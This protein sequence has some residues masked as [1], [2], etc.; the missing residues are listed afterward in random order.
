MMRAWLNGRRNLF[1]PAYD[2]PAESGSAVY[3]LV[4]ELGADAQFIA[5]IHAQ[6]ESS[7]RGGREIVFQYLGDQGAAVTRKFSVLDVME[8]NDRVTSAF[9]RI[10]GSEIPGAGIRLISA[11]VTLQVED[12]DRKFAEQKADLSRQARFHADDAE[13]TLARL[14]AIRDMFLRD[15][16]MAG[17]W[18]SEGKPERLLELAAH[19]NE[20]S[21]IVSLL[22]GTDT[23]GA[24]ADKTGALI[25]VF[26]TN[27]SPDH[28][29]HLLD[30]LARVFTS[31]ERPD[32]AGMLRPT[33]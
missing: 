20:F 11:S 26:L 32:L 7:G 16:A 3:R 9:S 28:R 13:T 27:L 8:A 17:L 15:P 4:S 2:D 5:A 10:A 12:G 22:D 18:W 21:A 25:N 14:T 30:Q 33:A 6:W 29:A 24:E 19:K 31:Y 1:L 23:G